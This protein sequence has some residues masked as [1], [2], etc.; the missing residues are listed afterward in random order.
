MVK[1]TGGNKILDVVL[2]IFAI[3][4]I[5]AIVYLFIV[6]ITNLIRILGLKPKVKQLL[7]KGSL[8]FGHARALLSCLD[9]EK[10]AKIVI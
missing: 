8:S 6:Y 4:G 5:V 2:W 1:Q 10:V 9:Q 3:V 7:A